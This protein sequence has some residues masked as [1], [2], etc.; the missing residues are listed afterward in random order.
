M[1]TENEDWKIAGLT[2]K[3]GKSTGKYYDWLKIRTRRDNSEK[4][5][6]WKPGVK[7]YHTVESDENVGN[8]IYNLKDLSINE[9]E[10]KFYPLETSAA[11]KNYQ[12]QQHLQK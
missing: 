3:V 2:S 7:Q 6:D 10:E 4:S 11:M 9:S 5:I 8:Q 12:K 1:S